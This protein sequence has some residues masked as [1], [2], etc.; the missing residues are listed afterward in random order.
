MTTRE[1]SPGA[2]AKL[3]LGNGNGAAKELYRMV[4]GVWCGV[5]VDEVRG[6]GRA[7]PMIVCHS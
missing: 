2:R 3:E 7:D 1:G 4:C 5:C 6:R